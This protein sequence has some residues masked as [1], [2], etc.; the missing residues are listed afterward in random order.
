MTVRPD[1]W[2][3]RSAAMESACPAKYWCQSP[4]SRPA[5]LSQERVDVLALW[6]QVFQESLPLGNAFF[7]GPSPHNNLVVLNV[8]LDPG[9][10]G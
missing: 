10:C 9:A 3:S 4:S 7:R 8:K 6:Q 2:A 1:A 5:I